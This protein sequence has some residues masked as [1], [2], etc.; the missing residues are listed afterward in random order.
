M[1]AKEQVY[2]RMIYGD[3]L[4]ISSERA[5]V[6]VVCMSEGD[7]DSVLA[8]CRRLLENDLDS[9]I[10]RWILKD[11]VGLFKT[12]L[13]LRGVRIARLV[14]P[15]KGT[16]LGWCRVADCMMLGALDNL[17]GRREIDPALYAVWAALIRFR[18]QASMTALDASRVHDA[19]RACD[20]VA[21]PL[22]FCTVSELFSG[23]GF[24]QSFDVASQPYSR[25][26]AAMAIDCCT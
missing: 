20:I 10:P 6:N 26:A 17:N 2:A 18:R 7:R 5:I 25:Y 24:L 8:E 1:D 3:V 9:A 12:G 16:P 23:D 22:G 19:I 11:I 21:S 4:S 14:A 13:S 15:V